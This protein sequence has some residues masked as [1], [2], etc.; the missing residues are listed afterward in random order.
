MIKERGGFTLIEL[1]VVIA[2]IAILAGLL[3]PALGKAKS[4]ATLTVSVNN[5]KQL[6]LAVQSWAIDQ[7]QSTVPWRSPIGSRFTVGGIAAANNIF[8]NYM[9]MSNEIVNPKIL[10]CSADKEVTPAETWGNSEGGLANGS[11]RNNSCSYFIGLDAGVKSGGDPIPFELAQE[12]VVF[13]DRN[14][15]ATAGT[16]VN[17]S[18]GITPAGGVTG[19]SGVIPSSQWLVRSRYGHGNVGV[20]ALLDGSVHSTAK[21]DLNQFLA[22][23]EDGGSIHMQFPRP[24]NL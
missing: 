17:C 18:S 1:L 10:A 23:G 2:I 7:E 4:K 13:G 24:P 22:K 20:V 6:G 12:H 9:F 3:L 15:E 8:F 21:F 19:G 16:S 5:L 11:Y 14:M